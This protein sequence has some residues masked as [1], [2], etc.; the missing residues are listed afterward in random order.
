MASLYKMKKFTKIL[1]ARQK[2]NLKGV[3]QD[4]SKLHLLHYKTTVR[5]L[6]VT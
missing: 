2:F 4:E 3:T 5:V 1:H 6:R